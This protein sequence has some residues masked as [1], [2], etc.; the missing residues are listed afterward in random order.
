MKQKEEMPHDKSSVFDSASN[1]PHWMPFLCPQIARYYAAGLLL[2]CLSAA[3]L[4][5]AGAAVFNIALSGAKWRLR[6]RFLTYNFR[7][8]YHEIKGGDAS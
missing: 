4:V 5:P 2:M 1:L 8:C 6:P 7:L 3:V